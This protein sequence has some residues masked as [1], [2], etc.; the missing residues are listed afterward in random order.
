M[1]KEEG[2]SLELTIEGMASMAAI[3]AGF[4]GDDGG[5]MLLCT[6]HKID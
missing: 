1:P 2:I 4:G 5:T 3:S 6:K